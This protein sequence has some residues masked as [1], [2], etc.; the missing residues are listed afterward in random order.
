[1]KMERKNNEGRKRMTWKVEMREIIRKKRK[2]ERRGNN[3][4]RNN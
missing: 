4:K 1:M 2:I 3:G